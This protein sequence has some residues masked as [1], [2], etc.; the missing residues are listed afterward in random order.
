VSPST[1]SL[2]GVPLTFGADFNIISYSGS[3]DVTAN[4]AVPAVDSEGCTVEA[5]AGFAAGSVAL[6]ARGTCTFAEKC[7]AAEAAGAAAVVIYN[8]LDEDTAFL[9][10]GDSANA[11]SISSLSLTQALGLEIVATIEGCVRALILGHSGSCLKVALFPS[12]ASFFPWPSVFLGLFT[13]LGR[14][15]FLPPSFF[16]LTIINVTA[17]LMCIRC[18]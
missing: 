1:L 2:D 10:A 16:R 4:A 18:K 15:S 9:G 8:N 7:T 6:V 5:F 3:G 12:A 17:C 14:P 13:F 11:P